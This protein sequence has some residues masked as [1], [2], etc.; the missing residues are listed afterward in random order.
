MKNKL[1]NKIETEYN[2]IE[3][4]ITEIQRCLTQISSSVELIRY[5]NYFENEIEKNKNH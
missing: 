5:L 4:N 1:N 3:E 2:A